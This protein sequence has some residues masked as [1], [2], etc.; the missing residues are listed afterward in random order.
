M[1][2]LVHE[3]FVIVKLGQDE[4]MTVAMNW[5]L[6]K[7]WSRMLAENMKASPARLNIK[8]QNINGM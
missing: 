7:I 2:P 3:K 6:T 5:K 1:V 8:Y 4:F